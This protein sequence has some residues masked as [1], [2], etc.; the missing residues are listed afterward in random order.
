MDGPEES[1][2][3]KNGSVHDAIRRR[4]DETRLDRVYNRDTQATGIPSYCCCL[5]G[6]S[7]HRMGVRRWACMLD[8]NGLDAIA[9]HWARVA[10]MRT[11]I[12]YIFG[13]CFVGGVLEKQGR[14]GVALRCLCFLVLR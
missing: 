5:F 11:M 7:A 10:G 6:I 2:G 9:S 12:S 3:L 8:C 4:R 13:L 1:D 14:V